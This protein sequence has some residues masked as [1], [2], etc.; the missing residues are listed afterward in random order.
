MRSKILFFKGNS[1][2]MR[3]HEMNKLGEISQLVMKK[4]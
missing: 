3:G 2:G 4:C 1:R